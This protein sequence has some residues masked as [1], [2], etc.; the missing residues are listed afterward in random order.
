VIKDENEGI[1]IFKKF[2]KV[3]YI[4]SFSLILYI[5]DN[6]MFSHLRKSL[7]ICE[8]FMDTFC[9]T[10]DNLFLNV[11]SIK[12]IKTTLLVN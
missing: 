5:L 4:K 6:R 7:K 10:L 2:Y 1:N 3:K 11:N 12:N 9:I 8:E